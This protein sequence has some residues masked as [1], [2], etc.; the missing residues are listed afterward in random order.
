MG[1]NDWKERGFCAEPCETH[2]LLGWLVGSGGG[3]F[4]Y[5]VAGPGSVPVEI[6]HHRSKLFDPSMCVKSR[7]SLKRMTFSSDVHDG[8]LM[9]WICLRDLNILL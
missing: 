4:N 6:F 7:L 3:F 1:F 8:S 9:I 2:D 5:E